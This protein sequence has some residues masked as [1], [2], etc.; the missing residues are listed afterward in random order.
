MFGGWETESFNAETLRRGD[1]MQGH[2]DRVWKSQIRAPQG[3]G[4]KRNKEEGERR[5]EEGK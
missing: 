4:G 5:R 1:A 3:G 2:R